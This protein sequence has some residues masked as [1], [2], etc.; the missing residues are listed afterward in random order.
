M[1]INIAYPRRGTQTKFEYKDEKQW[2]KLYEFKVGQEVGGELFGQNF[3][4]YIFRITGGSDNNGFGMKQGVLTKNKVKLLLDGTGSGYF[5]KRT[6]TQR[7]KSVRGCII[8]REISSL[9]MVVVQKGEKEIE[10][11]TNIRN[12]LRLGPK[13]ANKIRKLF[14][15]PRHYDNRGKKDAEKVVVNNVD[16]CRAVVRRPT[17]SVGEKKYYKAPRITRLL[18]TERLR[19][20]KQ[21]RS[22]K[23]QRCIK[24]Q[25]SMKTHSKLLGELKAQAIARKKSS[26]K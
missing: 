1:I 10:G 22:T 6:G 14:N 3:E 5:Q 8:G 23:L 11:L 21:K 2:Q 15:L 20:K 16:V 4:G 26:R 25:E 9:N 7:R 24:N 13:R 19:R 17:K 12:P 18:T